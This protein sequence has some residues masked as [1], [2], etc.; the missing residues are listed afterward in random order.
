[1]FAKVRHIISG[2]TK[3]IAAVYL[4][5]FSG[6]S[7]T[8][9]FN[10]EYAKLTPQF[11]ALLPA[12]SAPNIAR[13]RISSAQQALYSSL[14]NQGCTL[15]ESSY[16]EEFCSEASKCTPLNQNIT[17]ILSAKY[18]IDAFFQLSI[19]SIQTTNILAAYYNSVSGKLAAYDTSAQQI[20]VVTHTERQSG[21]IL[22]QSGQ[23]FQGINEQLS[24]QQGNTALPLISSFITHLTEK[25]PKITHNQKSIEIPHITGTSIVRRDESVHDICLLGTPSLKGTVTI[26]KVV[27]PL[28]EVT[29][30]RYCGTYRL[31]GV[32]SELK[33]D[34]RS[35]F[36]A[37]D[38]RVLSIPN[39]DPC[40]IVTGISR[41][42]NNLVYTCDN[43]CNKEACMPFESLVYTAQDEIG[44]Y[45]KSSS[46]IKPRES[47]LFTV[48]TKTST[49]IVSLPF[50]L[51]VSQ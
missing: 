48:L 38:R 40:Q 14:A 8:A 21:G 27:S 44:P 39:F 13:E 5:F 2:T 49:G 3:L 51:K 30:G 6:C 28:R 26:L 43:R 22:L 10:P 25:L 45:T 35:P 41:I 20:G 32:E 1:M 46:S 9:S 4:F 15:L 23:I 11:I 18:G 36:G 17:Q 50:S 33:V 24:Q 37:V 34:L 12:I 16:I 29:P 42:S 31:E 47:D 7:S 19:D